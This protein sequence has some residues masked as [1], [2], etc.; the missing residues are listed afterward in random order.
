MSR[1]IPKNVEAAFAE[2]DGQSDRAVILVAGSLLDHALAEAIMSRLRKPQTDAEW[3][4][5]FDDGGPA[6]TFSQKITLAYFLRIIGPVTRRDIDLIRK[7]RNAAA[8]DMNPVSFE[9]SEEI[10]NRVRQLVRTE[11]YDGLLPLRTR[12]EAAATTYV[13]RLMARSADLT[14]EIAETLKSYAA[15]LDR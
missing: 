6:S 7:I 8:H 4:P 3:K 1:Y 12:F 2:L 10:S 5:L 13:V 9:G 11:E 15:E 14:P